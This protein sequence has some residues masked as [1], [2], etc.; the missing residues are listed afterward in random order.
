MYIIYEGKDGSVAISVLA[1]HVKMEDIEEIV[2]KFRE[3]HPEGMYP[4]YS[5]V[6]KI[7]APQDRQFRDAWVKRGNKIVVDEH[8]ALKIHLERVREARNKK[9]EELD[10]EQ[11]Q[12]LSDTWKIQEI[13]TKKQALRDLPVSINTLDWP[14]ALS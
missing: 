5:V 1:E 6:D 10:K 4:R 3:V 13:E 8:K 12:Y 7:N 14:E 2:E 9:L 11:L